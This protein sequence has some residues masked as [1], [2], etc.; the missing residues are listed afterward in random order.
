MNLIP[1][2]VTTFSSQKSGV[3]W[4]CCVNTKLRQW[5][6]SSLGITVI[7]LEGSATLRHRINRE[8]GQHRKPEML[9]R[10][11]Y[12]QA[13][14]LK[15]LLKRVGCWTRSKTFNPSQAGQSGTKLWFW[16]CDLKDNL[17]KVMCSRMMFFVAAV[18][19]VGS[20]RSEGLDQGLWGW[21]WEQPPSCLQGDKP[22]H[23]QGYQPTYTV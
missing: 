10:Q 15:T 22:S 14:L 20:I 13:G 5:A 7:G 11:I 19:V 18:V 23:T 8:E 2:K 9:T 3:Y 16:H 1:G 12:A 17:L 6:N 4:P 21:P